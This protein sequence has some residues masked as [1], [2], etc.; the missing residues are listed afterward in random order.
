MTCALPGEFFESVIVKRFV[1]REASYEDA[2]LIFTGRGDV[3]PVS[4][5]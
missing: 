5:L 4:G 1:F 2:D 3:S